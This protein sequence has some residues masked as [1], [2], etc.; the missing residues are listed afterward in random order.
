MG[1]L[2]TD[3]WLKVSLKNPL[4]ICRKIKKLF[5]EDS[6]QRVYNYLARNGMYK[7]NARIQND[8]AKL[9]ENKVWD[10]VEG[11]FKRYKKL[12][13]GPNIPI[14]I[15]PHGSAGF[16]HSNK[17]NKSGLAFKDKMFLFYTPGLSDRELE[18][19]FVHEYH[20]VCRL[21][22]LKKEINDYTLLDSIILEGLAEHAVLKNVG[23]SFLAEWTRFY[24]SDAALKLGTKYIKPHLQLRKNDDLHDQLLYGLGRFPKM[25]GYSC[26][27]HA[28]TKRKKN[29]YISEIATL[30]KPSEYFLEDYFKD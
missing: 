12:W 24:S 30:T 5:Q 14:F 11:F 16:F 17:G 27:F 1:V 19:V 15:F 26:G 29:K 20:H 3:E 28:V 2:K 8:F 23:V 18:A 10:K 9:L 13:D 21:N 7:Y 25:I 4:E 22:F 6:E